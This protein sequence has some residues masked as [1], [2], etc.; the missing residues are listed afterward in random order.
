MTDL[1]GFVFF[2]FHKSGPV[3]K[4]FSII[5]VWL[6]WVDEGMVTVLY[7][8]DRD[9]YPYA[10]IIIKP[11]LLALIKIQYQSFTSG[12]SCQFFPIY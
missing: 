4:G 8:T 9:P 10:I 6:F 12:L 11:Q 5:N 1:T 7:V 2:Y 3:S